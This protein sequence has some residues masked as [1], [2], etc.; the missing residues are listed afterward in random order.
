MLS[1]MSTIEGIDQTVVNTNEQ[2]I[3]LRY[4]SQSKHSSNEKVSK[5]RMCAKMLRKN[6]NV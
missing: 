1:E 5:L 4:N 3:Q 2:P 6:I